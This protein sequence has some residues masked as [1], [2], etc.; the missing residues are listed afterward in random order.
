M[1]ENRETKFQIITLCNSVYV[2]TRTTIFLKSE[3]TNRDW[4][5]QNEWWLNN[6]ITKQRLLAIA[7]YRPQARQDLKLFK[8]ESE[9]CLSR[10]VNPSQGSRLSS[11]N[12]ASKNVGSWYQI[13]LNS[14]IW[15]FVHDRSFV[16]LHYP[17][18]LLSQIRIH[19]HST[20]YE[21]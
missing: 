4:I 15:K 21:S 6:S 20:D 2:A 19:C 11:L 12:T 14:R 16:E 8:F 18:D 5:S 1:T 17:I 10:C 3:S 9:D 7:G 13:G